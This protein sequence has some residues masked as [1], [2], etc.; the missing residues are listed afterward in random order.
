MQ[1]L[2]NEGVK[3][4]FW[5]TFSTLLFD[6][7]GFAIYFAV[8]YLVAAQFFK[9][10][11]TLGI[12]YLIPL[13]WG[14]FLFFV[15][16]LAEDGQTPGQKASNIFVHRKDGKEYKKAGS[17]GGIGYVKATLV[18][19]I[20][21]G[22]FPVLALWALYTNFTYLNLAIVLVIYLLSLLA[23]AVIEDSLFGLVK[24]R[25]VRETEAKSRIR[26]FY[27]RQKLARPQLP[28]HAALIPFVMLVGGIIVGVYSAT[29][30]QTN[31]QAGLVG[32]VVGLISLF[33]AQAL[34]NVRT[35]AR[36]VTI[37]FLIA[38]AVATVLYSFS[39]LQTTV[40]VVLAALFVIDLLV[41]PT[42]ANAFRPAT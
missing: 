22:V 20:S 4:T 21:R 38:A 24:V 14:Y 8:S 34:L 13:V 3:P 7:L 40:T 29:N 6:S 9:I 33:L 10:H 25:F 30:Y 12:I 41:D 1:G 27:E 2:S 39:P 15:G 42:V 16:P 23:F 11:W 26:R 31:P 28:L 35:W 5:H 18:W 37:V 32:V 36:W 17:T 19:I